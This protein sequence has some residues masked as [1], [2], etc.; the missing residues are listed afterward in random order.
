ML[1]P[2]LLSLLRLDLFAANV[3][4]ARRDVDWK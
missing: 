4:V 3:V 1:P 2:E